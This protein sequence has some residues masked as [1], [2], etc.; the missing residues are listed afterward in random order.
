MSLGPHVVLVALLASTPFAC[1]LWSRSRHPRPSGGR[2]EGTLLLAAL[3]A[4]VPSR[5]EAYDAWI[6]EHPPGSVLELRE[7]ALDGTLFGLDVLAPAT[8]PASGAASV[9]R[10]LVVVGLAALLSSRADAR[11]CPA[12]ERA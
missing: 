1:V 9:A 6:E 5:W 4:G 12:V 3:D 2:V 7:R 8:T 10:R 11:R